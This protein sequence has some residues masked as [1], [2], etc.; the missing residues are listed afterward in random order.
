[1]LLKQQFKTW[2]GARKRAAFENAHCERRF[3]FLVVRCVNGE[4]DPNNF[5]PIIMDMG[6]YTWR[7]AKWS[8]K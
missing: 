5:E 7:L 4:P 6:R 3:T 1:M 2:E 8:T